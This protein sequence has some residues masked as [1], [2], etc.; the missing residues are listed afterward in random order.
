ML[1]LCP[2]WGLRG[3]EGPPG[4]ASSATPIRGSS[5]QLKAA[6]MALAAWPPEGSSPPTGGCALASLEG[7]G[8][9]RGHLTSTSPPACCAPAGAPSTPAHRQNQPTSPQPPPTVGVPTAACLGGATSRV[10]SWEQGPCP[11]C[12]PLYLPSVGSRRACWSQS[13]ARSACGASG[14]RGG[15]GRGCLQA[16]A[17][18]RACGRFPGVGP[19]EDA[20]RA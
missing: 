13:Q 16:S 6:A 20:P 7:G 3:D 15:G 11:V 19:T 1:P 12:S 18:S 9:P 8:P 4:T 5:G 14:A 2:C 10:P 17:L